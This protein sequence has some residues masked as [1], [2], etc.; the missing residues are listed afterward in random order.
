MDRLAALLL[1]FG[2]CVL[3]PLGLLRVFYDLRQRIGQQ[4][5][6]SHDSGPAIHDPRVEQFRR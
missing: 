1:F 3:L 4:R 2:F 6:L 5:P